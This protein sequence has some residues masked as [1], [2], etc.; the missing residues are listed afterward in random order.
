MSENF[1]CGYVIYQVGD[2]TFRVYKLDQNGKRTL[3]KNKDA[4]D[5]AYEF[6]ANAVCAVIKQ[7][8]K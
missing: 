1:E 5:N 7:L 4:E 2:G 8:T 3:I 6:Y